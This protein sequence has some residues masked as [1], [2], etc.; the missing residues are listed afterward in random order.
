MTTLDRIRSINQSMLYIDAEI[1]RLENEKTDENREE[2]EK[3][4][5]SFSKKFRLLSQEKDK[6]H[7]EVVST[8]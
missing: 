3:E 7:R 4:I 2:E 6:L 1:A 8:L 5:E